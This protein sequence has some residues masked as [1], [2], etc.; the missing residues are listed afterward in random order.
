M[1][2]VLV[3]LV[4]S[5]CANCSAAQSCKR[6]PRHVV[7]LALYA[8]CVLLVGGRVAAAV[9]C[10][11]YLHASVQALQDIDSSLMTRMLP[12]F[13]LH[14]RLQTAST[15]RCQNLT[16]AN[17][18][19]TYPNRQGIKTNAYGACASTIDCAS[20]QPQEIAWPSQ[21]SALQQAQASDQVKHVGIAPT[22]PAVGRMAG[23]VLGLGSVRCTL[24]K[25]EHTLM[26]CILQPPAY[27][28]LVLMPARPC[29]HKLPLQMVASCPGSLHALRVLRHVLPVP[30]M[31]STYAEAESY[32]S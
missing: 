14:D 19:I 1:V 16:S 5:E 7:M 18:C 25:V 15:P 27:H 21:G 13:T 20:D 8:L 23:P 11:T 12:W 24:Q 6:W 32:H 17:N 29:P 26:R 30:S 9:S 28:I 4:H 2:L 31:R 10:T 22:H 3:V